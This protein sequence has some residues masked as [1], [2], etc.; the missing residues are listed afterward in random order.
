[1]TTILIFLAWL[2]RRPIRYQVETCHL[3]VMWIDIGRT[4]TLAEARAIARDDKLTQWV[5]TGVVRETRVRD[6][7]PI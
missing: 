4:R 5:M 7:S 6:I 2:T 3:G 1:M